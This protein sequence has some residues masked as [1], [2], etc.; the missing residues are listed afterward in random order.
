MSFALDVNILLLA[1]NSESPDHASA[2]RALKRLE[3]AED[4]VYVAWITIMAYLR[5]ATHP[6]IFRKPLTPSEARSNVDSLIGLPNVRLLSEGEGFW[7]VYKRIG[8]D[9]PLRGNLVPDAH[10]VA[11]LKQHGVGRIHTR[12]RDF[13][14]FQGLT[15]I[16]PLVEE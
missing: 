4:L 9:L 16:D 8:D 15:V 14:K 6:A 5:I 10:L 1:S 3:G 12:D 7:D 11:I 2:V 13:K